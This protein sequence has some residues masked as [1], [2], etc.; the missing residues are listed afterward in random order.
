MD[1]TR[2]ARMISKAGKRGQPPVVHRLEVV[3]YYV[4][5]LIRKWF[6]SA[7]GVKRARSPRYSGWELEVP[8][9]WIRRL[10]IGEPQASRSVATNIAVRFQPGR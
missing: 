5:A 7:G 6:A 2:H 4:N 3:H 1:A 8:D 10:L 9:V